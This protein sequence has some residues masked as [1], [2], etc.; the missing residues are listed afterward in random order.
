MAKWHGIIGY[1]ITHEPDE[2]NDVWRE[3]TVEKHHYGDLLENVRQ[4]EQ[5]ESVIDN[6]KLNNKLSILANG[7][8]AEHWGAIRYAVI[9]GVKWKATSVNFQRPRLILT[10]GGVWNGG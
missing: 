2:N 7:F 4:Y 6:L 10:F 3:E 9:D 8:A 1:V 5:G